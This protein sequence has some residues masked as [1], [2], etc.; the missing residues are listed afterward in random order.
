MRIVSRVAD[1]EED[2][3][4]MH[5]EGTGVE[6]CVHEESGHGMGG[7][8]LA[9]DGGDEYAL[10]DVGA[11][12]LLA[13]GAEE[14]GQAG[15]DLSALRLFSGQKDEQVGI[16]AAKPCDELAVAEN[17]LGVGGAGEQA[18][19]GFRIFFC[20]GQVGP[21]ED[22]AVGVGGIGGGELEELRFFGSGRGAQLAEQIDGGGEGELGC[23]EAGDK[24]A[25]A[26]AAAFF[27][28]LEHVVDDAEAARNVFSGD[29]FADED[30]VA[31]EELEGE[32]VTGL[33]GRWGQGR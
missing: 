23:A 9:V 30:A 20:D 24:V 16:A 25:A 22:G 21:A 28:S 19:G 14:V 15:G 27:K 1:G 10:M 32:G 3:A 11:Q 2:A 33:G 6:A 12:T 31:V 18:G 13:A 5:A 29:G 4:Q 7:D 8:R 17:D 26:D